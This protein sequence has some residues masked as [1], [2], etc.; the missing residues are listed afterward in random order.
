M[1]FSTQKKEKSLRDWDPHRSLSIS[2]FLCARWLGLL[3]GFTFQKQLKKLVNAIETIVDGVF[4]AHDS[5][6]HAC[7]RL[8]R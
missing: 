5:T 7:R 2:P 4:S 1:F 6:R 8:T 3:V